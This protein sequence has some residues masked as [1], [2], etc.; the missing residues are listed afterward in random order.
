MQKEVLN[1]RQEMKVLSIIVKYLPPF[2]AIMYFLNSVLSMLGIYISS[3]SHCCY[4]GLLPLFIIYVCCSVLKYCIQYKAYL[5]YIV[6]NDII[7]WI[8]YEY[9][10]TEDIMIGWIIVLGTFFCLISY[11]MIK[12]IYNKEAIL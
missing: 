11:L 1:Y 2:I 4:C 5:W 3:I 6:I 10:F 8:D 7:N 9:S 12:H